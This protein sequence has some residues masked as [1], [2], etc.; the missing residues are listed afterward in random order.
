MR[1][2]HLAMALSMLACSSVFAQGATQAADLLIRPDLGKLDLS[3]RRLV[4]LAELHATDSGR[5]V[6]PKAAKLGELA[7]H[8]PEK[9]A[10]GV[11][12]PFGRFREVVLDRPYADTATG[13]TVYQWMVE[14]FRGSSLATTIPTRRTLSPNR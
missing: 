10:P 9:V 7:R 8:F 13:K 3:V 5:F 11:G 14:R 4:S 12:I 6:G 2:L 1:A